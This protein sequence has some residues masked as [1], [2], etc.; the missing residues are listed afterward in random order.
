MRGRGWSWLCL[1]AFLSSGAAWAQERPDKSA[2]G[3]LPRH[4]R[5]PD[6]TEY[7]AGE[8]LVKFKPILTA[9]DLAQYGVRV[10]STVPDRATA[11]RAFHA[12]HRTRP[13]GAPLFGWQR[14]LLPAGQSVPAVLA[15]LGQDPLV[16]GVEPHG[17]V[18]AADLSTTYTAL[19]GPT[20]PIYQDGS[21]EWWLNR[22]QADRF[23]NVAAAWAN[24][25][26]VVAVVDTGV[27][28]SHPELAGRLAPG[29]NV[30]NP[31]APPDDD[32]LVDNGH[33]THVAGLIV[34]NAD[35]GQ[36]IAGAAQPTLTTRVQVMPVK[37]LDASANGSIMDV[38]TGI[39]WAA[40]HGADV[41]SLSLGT[42]TNDS[43]L[44]NAC[45]YAANSRNCFLAAAAGNDN[46]N[47]NTSPYYPAM[48]D[49]VFCVGATDAQDYVTY[50]S[51]YGNGAIDVAGRGVA[52]V[53]AGLRPGLR[54]Y[55]HGHGQRLDPQGRHVFFRAAGFGRGGPAVAAEPHPH[56]GPTAHAD[57][58]QLRQPPG[59]T[60]PK[61]RRRPDQR[62][63]RARRF[64][65]SDLHTFPDANSHSHAH[66]TSHSYSNPH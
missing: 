16:A 1:A 2:L 54:G 9:Q 22:T 7:V 8:V 6:A 23:M 42:Y 65:E 40:D 50:Y 46:I 44:Q 3:S 49:S 66:P 52:R 48:Y 55:Q 36:G 28:L 61:H 34:A 33:G 20:D 19:A 47:L 18:Y 4:H 45:D 13:A 57:H 41:I 11:L 27:Q 64:D 29:F 25:T 62:L 53:L 26:V 35:N 39:A 43:V 12:F 38:A 14:V 10:G 31:G 37:V 32:N 17:R 21:S 51:N 63:V 59:R 24:T 30:L 5:F 56:H 58:R 15:E 60:R